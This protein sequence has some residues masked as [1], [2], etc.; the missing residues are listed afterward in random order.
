LKQ[1]N[2]QILYVEGEGCAW[3]RNGL[4]ERLSPTQESDPLGAAIGTACVSLKIP[5]TNRLVNETIKELRRI[6]QHETIKWDAHGK[7]PIIGTDERPS[8]GY[9]RSN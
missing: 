5:P 9:L 3:Y 2:E 8:G 4:W 1:R 7:I 6:L